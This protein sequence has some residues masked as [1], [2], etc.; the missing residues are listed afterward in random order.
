MYISSYLIRTRTPSGE[1]MEN[2]LVAPRTMVR[3]FF[4]AF[5]PRCTLL[6]VILPSLS[7]AEGG[8]LF[9]KVAIVTI[10]Y[11]LPLYTA[12]TPVY[13]SSIATP[14]I[15]S[16]FFTSSQFTSTVEPYFNIL[17]HPVSEPPTQGSPVMRW[18]RKGQSQV[19]IQEVEDDE[20]IDKF[21]TILKCQ[22]GEVA[23]PL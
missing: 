20:E 19:N 9:S 7:I 1:T 17:T 15:E 23:I 18:K 6:W 3:I 10:I 5:P 11:L 8:D 4:L 21:R 12:S 16:S 14:L 22:W 2:M 13:Y